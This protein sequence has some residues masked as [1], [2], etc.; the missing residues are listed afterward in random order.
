MQKYIPTV[1]LQ[2]GKVVRAGRVPVETDQGGSIDRGFR[3]G[4]AQEPSVLPGA[5]DAL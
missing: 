2:V 5:G 3:I 4:R 1:G